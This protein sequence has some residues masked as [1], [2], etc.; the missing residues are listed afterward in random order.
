[1]AQEFCYKCDKLA[2][3]TLKGRHYCSIH[4]IEEQ[5]E[6]KDYLIKKA[7]EARL[8]ITKRK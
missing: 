3:V 4:A 8:K 6:L 2:T 5:A 1:M 7:E